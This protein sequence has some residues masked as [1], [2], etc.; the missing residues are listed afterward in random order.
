VPHIDFDIDHLELKVDD[1]IWLGIGEASIRVYGD[2]RVQ[3]FE[4]TQ[5]VFELNL[6]EFAKKAANE[7]RNPGD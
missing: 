3:L 4:Q 7:S 6:P 2:G 5:L 1:Y